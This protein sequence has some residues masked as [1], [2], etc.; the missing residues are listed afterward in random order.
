[1]RRA[2]RNSCRTV[3]A[4]LTHNSDLTVGTHVLVAL[5]F[6]SALEFL[7]LQNALSKINSPRP[8][9]GEGGSHP[10]PSPAGARRVRGSIS[11]RLIPTPP[12]ADHAASKTFCTNDSGASWTMPFANRSTMYLISMHRSKHHAA[13]S[14]SVGVWRSSC[15]FLIDAPVRARERVVR[16]GRTP[17]IVSAVP[18]LRDPLTRLAPADDNAG[19]SPPSP[20]RGRGRGI[21]RSA[22]VFIPWFRSSNVETPA[23]TFRSARADLKV[24]ATFKL[25]H[26]LRRSL[27]FWR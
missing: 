8:L 16:R 15:A 23:L 25:G 3:N 17:F 7:H 4:T 9:G 5:T 22:L 1:M 6:R 12:V 18:T 14:V 21:Y 13:R 27:A 24:G 19:G 26:Y 10:A 11:E 20:P 2:A